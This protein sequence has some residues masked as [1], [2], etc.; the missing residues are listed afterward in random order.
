MIQK[1]MDRG[2][3]YEENILPTHSYTF[4]GPCVI[5]GKKHEVTVPAEELFAYRQGLTIQEAMTSLDKDQREFLMS[6]ISPDG[7]EKD[8]HTTQQENH[9]P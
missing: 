8:N 4:T 6:G 3:T 5:T 2:C 9:T 7:W 1:Y